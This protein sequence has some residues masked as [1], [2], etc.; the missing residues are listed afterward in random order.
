M[1][2]D[3]KSLEGIFVSAQ[4]SSGDASFIYITYL[5]PI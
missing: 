5:L 4:P 2:T 3:F 1:P